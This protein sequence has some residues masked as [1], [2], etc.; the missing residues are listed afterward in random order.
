M[1]DNRPRTLQI[2]LEYADEV[3]DEFADVADC[4]ARLTAESIRY[5][6]SDTLRGVG[7]THADVIRDISQYWHGRFFSDDYLHCDIACDGA[8]DYVTACHEAGATVVYLTG[9]DVPGML[10]GTVAS[11][12]DH[13]FPLG[14]AG[15]ELVLK[16]D[17]S[18]AD[19]AF[20]RM[21][22]P[23]LTRVGEVVGFFD[24]EPANCNTALSL[25]PH[26]DVVLL[27]TVRLEGAPDVDPAVHRLVDFRIL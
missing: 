1:F 13:G 6:L 12:R 16:P 3:R 23:T 9:R 25:Y 19:E 14:K 4:L 15:V 10:L 7:L 17:A 21:A 27:E 26:A 24:N 5:L 8:A 18:L 22:L 20:K 11:L 2:L